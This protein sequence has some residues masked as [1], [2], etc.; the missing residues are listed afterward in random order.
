VLEGLLEYELARRKSAAVTKARKRAE[1]YLLE[2]RM[3]RSLRTGEVISKRWLRFSFPTFWHYDVLRGA[4]FCGM[5]ESNPTG[6][7]TSFIPNI[8]HWRW[9]PVSAGQAAGTHCV[10]SEFWVG[11][12]TQ[13]GGCDLGLLALWLRSES[14]REFAIR[15]GSRYAEVIPED[16]IAPSLPA[17]RQP[18]RNRLSGDGW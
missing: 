10:L 17:C 16:S 6:R 14:C 8:F 3:F 12:T 18:P 13:R 2:R 9:R 4:N 11:T 5:P 1:N 7:S 15:S